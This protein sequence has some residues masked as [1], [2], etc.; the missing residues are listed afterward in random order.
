MFTTH[1]VM[2]HHGNTQPSS[3]AAKFP[4][5]SSSLV[6]YAQKIF[7][8]NRAGGT[9]MSDLN[10]YFFKMANPLFVQFLRFLFAMQEYPHLVRCHRHTEIPRHNKIVVHLLYRHI[11]SS[12]RR[13]RKADNKRKGKLKKREKI[14]ADYKDEL[15]LLMLKSI[16]VLLL[17]LK[18]QV[19]ISLRMLLINQWYRC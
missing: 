1:T 7:N 9:H 10:V 11:Q 15:P 17:S 18:H 14:I 13:R 6:H 5:F 4:P 2:H 19:R 16:I 8:E 12:E 3:L